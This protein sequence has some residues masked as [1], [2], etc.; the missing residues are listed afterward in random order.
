[1]VDEYTEL[2]GPLSIARVS[3]ARA[4]LRAASQLVRDTYP[5]IE[6]RIA[7]RSAT[8]TDAR[9][10]P[11]RH[12]L[13]GLL[14]VARRG[15]HAD[16]PPGS[17]PVRHHHIGR[18]RTTTPAL[19]PKAGSAESQTLVADRLGRSTGI[20]RGWRARPACQRFVGTSRRRLPTVAALPYGQKL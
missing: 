5:S 19:E 4:L 16:P 7:S 20:G 12:G 14:R 15:P 1:M 6:V 18:T 9:L 2:F 13:R 10:P 17:A 8:L 3:L 11:P